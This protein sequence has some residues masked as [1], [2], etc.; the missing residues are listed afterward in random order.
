MIATHLLSG[1]FKVQG[2]FCS[3]L[4]RLGRVGGPGRNDCRIGLTAI[5]EQ[6]LKVFM[7]MFAMG[8]SDLKPELGDGNSPPA[9][10]DTTLVAAAKAGDQWAFVELCNRSSPM[11]YRVIYPLVR[12]PADAE[13]VL[14]ESFL[15]AFRGL[16]H[17][18]QRAAFSTWLIRIGI[19][20]ALLIL[21]KRNKYRED[22]RCRRFN[23]ETAWELDIADNAAGPDELCIQTELVINLHQAIAR[24]PTRLRIVLE[25]Q[26]ASGA[27]IQEISAA[28]NIS[29][30]AAKTRLFRGRRALRRLLK[31]QNLLLRT[32]NPDDGEKQFISQ[33]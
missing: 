11:L 6:T 17:F 22:S 19:N 10:H 20:S 25:L 23:E 7:A 33:A 4:S 12:N 32:C 9:T 14:Q 2:C 30:P 16:K 24:L 28:L 29:I 26:Y 21:R 5:R 3:L 27:S 1:Y 13:D 8:I 18:D 15:K 31:S